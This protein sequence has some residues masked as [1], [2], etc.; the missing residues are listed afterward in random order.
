MQTAVDAAAAEATAQPFMDD[1]IAKNAQ[2]LSGQL[3]TLMNRLFPPQS[4]KTLRHFSGGEVARILG[5]TDGYLRQ[6]MLGGDFVEPEK[7]TAG[8]RL[9]TLR[10]IHEIRDHL[11][12]AKPAY[13]RRRSGQEHLQVVAVTNFKGGSGK[14]T[15]STHLAQYLVLHG[16]RVLAIDLDP[17]ASMSS[18]LGLQPELDQ[19][20]NQ[21][22][23]GA[24]R[25]DEKQVPLSSII[26]PTY[27]TG[28]NLVSGNLELMEFEHDTPRMLADKK[29][30]DALFFARVARAI[31]TVEKDYDVVV[32]DCPPQLG[33]LTLGALCAATGIV[34]TIN[35]QMLDVASMAQFLTMAAGL[36]SV[37]RAAGADL[38][39]DFLRYAI[40]RFEPND[41]PQAQVAAFLRNL[42]G[43]LV[44]TN[45]MLK[46]TAI[47]D[48]G[49]LKQT[50]YEISRDQLNKQTYDR[51]MES[52]D[53]LNGEIE[54]TIR[55]AWGRA[56]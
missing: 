7:G 45:A 28:L 49:L 6:R 34:I 13:I 23:Y 42:F 48:A 53:T 43:E 11:G 37:V 24:I 56:A 50:L 44:L 33:F 27:F 40:T 41:G 8:R 46:S 51:A 54:L 3:T 29:N 1:L 32:I 38:K 52:M 36:L 14:T 5:I 21:T 18:L 9:Y 2:A 10:Q 20:E 19:S 31:A 39:Y 16:Y 17:Q 25:Y 30:H 4:Q 22:L 55:R 15:T 35:S 26:R 12:R 47:S